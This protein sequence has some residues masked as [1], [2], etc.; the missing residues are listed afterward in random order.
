MSALSTWIA[1]ALAGSGLILTDGARSTASRSDHRGI[2]PEATCLAG[3]APRS[4][5]NKSSG[6]VD[7]GAA[8]CTAVGPRRTRGAVDSV[9][10]ESSRIARC[11]GCSTDPFV[12]CR[13][14]ITFKT[15]TV[16]CC[17]C[18]PAALALLTA[19]IIP[20]VLAAAAR[21]TIR[22]VWLAEFASAALV[23][24]HGACLTCELATWTAAALGRPPTTLVGVLA[25][26]AFFARIAIFVQIVPWITL[27]SW[28]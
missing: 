1:F 6:A 4:G 19:R 10:A 24:F 2:G 26:F 12:C 9:H 16:L 7:A 18:I 23:T 21:V 15:G 8:P 25:D 20:H 17:R 22:P 14:G 5:S 28:H 13:P 27:C 11:A 3:G